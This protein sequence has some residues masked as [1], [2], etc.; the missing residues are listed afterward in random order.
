MTR[1]RVTLDAVGAIL[2]ALVWIS[3]LVFAAW[4]AEEPGLLGSTE[5]VEQHADRLRSQAVAYINTDGNSRGFLRMSGSHTLER[6]INEVAHDVLDPQTGVS[7]SARLAARRAALSSFVENPC[8][9]L[10][11]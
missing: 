5:W 10:R 3:P 11:F 8:A 9:I 7:V 1:P 6:F 2:L 4:D